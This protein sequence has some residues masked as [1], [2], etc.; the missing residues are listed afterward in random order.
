MRSNPD[1]RIPIHN[2]GNRDRQ[3]SPGRHLHDPTLVCLEHV[4]RNVRDSRYGWIGR[5]DLFSEVWCSETTARLDRGNGDS[6]EAH[7][8][9]LRD[10]TLR[11]SCSASFKTTLNCDN[12]IPPTRDRSVQSFVRAIR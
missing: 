8:L 12:L 5:L 6:V 1:N 3:Q 9:G 7:H 2:I 11:G 4:A 10:I